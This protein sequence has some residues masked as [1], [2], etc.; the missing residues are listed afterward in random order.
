MFHSTR[1]CSSRR[2]PPGRALRLRII[3]ART[4]KLRVAGE[5]RI[6]LLTQ[7]L[8]LGGQRQ[9]FCLPVA[10]EFG[11]LPERRAGLP[12]AFVDEFCRAPDIVPLISR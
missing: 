4:A 2:L 1:L 9:R 12:L 10:V 5:Y 6:D 11:A 8:G 7:R 3:Q